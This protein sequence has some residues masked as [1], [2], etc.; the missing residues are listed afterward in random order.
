MLSLSGPYLAITALLALGGVLK[1]TRPTETTTA[2]EALALPAHHWLV[3]VLGV[4]EITIGGL[5]FFSATALFSV[6]TSL[7]Y[8]TFAGFVALARHSSTPV[9][10]C[11]CFGKAETPPSVIHIV[12]NLAAATVAGLIAI[13]PIPV[14]N[15][16][17]AGQPNSGITLLALVA[18]M[19]YLVYVSLTI[20][21]QTLGEMQRT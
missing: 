4:A 10:S 13:R 3:R 15:E 18:L 14:L 11:G 7:A 16:L 6:L 12:F 17:L 1:V 20:L 19:V 2:L 21:P 8:L 9:Q 5:A